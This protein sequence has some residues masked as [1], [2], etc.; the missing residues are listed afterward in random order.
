MRDLSGGSSGGSFAIPEV[1]SDPGSPAAGDA[2][3]LRTGSGGSGGGEV[4][5]LF[6]LILTANTGG[7][8]TYE[9]S[10]YTQASTIVRTTLTP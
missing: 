8:F 1:A 3:V 2:W 5:A 4:K 9:L 7:G 6:P 10:Y